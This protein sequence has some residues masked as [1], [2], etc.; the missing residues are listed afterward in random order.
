MGRLALF[1]TPC[2]IRVTFAKFR[3]PPTPAQ[4]RVAV[5]S[6]PFA[7]RA[8]NSRKR[9]GWIVLPEHR[10]LVST[11][12]RSIRELR[13][14]DYQRNALPIFRSPVSGRKAE[15]PSVWKVTPYAARNRPDQV[16]ARQ[17]TEYKS[18]KII[19]LNLQT[20]GAGKTWGSRKSRSF[21]ARSASTCGG[22]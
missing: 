3:L 9:I 14:C 13:G 11:C 2:A 12:A 18:C 7:F 10:Q 4:D 20:K 21:T 1:N 19:I 6:R 17:E 16:A 22:G 8:V 5:I 15:N